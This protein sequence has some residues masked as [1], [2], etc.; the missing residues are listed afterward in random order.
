MLLFS[1]F[2]SS[3]ALHFAND[4]GIADNLLYLRPRRFKLDRF[5]VNTR[6][7]NLSFRNLMSLAVSQAA[8]WVAISH[9]EVLFQQVF[10]QTASEFLNEP[11]DK[12]LASFNK[13]NFRFNLKHVVLSVSH[14]CYDINNIEAYPTWT[15]TNHYWAN[16][17]QTHLIPTYILVSSSRQHRKLHISSLDEYG[18][19]YYKRFKQNFL[20]NTY[21]FVLILKRATVTTI[22]LGLFLCHDQFISNCCSD[23]SGWVMLKCQML[24]LFLHET[25]SP[26]LE[27]TE[28]DDCVMLV[29]IDTYLKLCTFTN[30]LLTISFFILIIIWP[31]FLNTTL[32]W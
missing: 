7:R 23:I 11:L 20:N 4:L 19:Y 1:K 10:K 15:H 3:S 6:K 24:P 26:M 17:K 14:K 12:V 27:I 25:V 9:S 13:L 32:L 2:S 18:I 21:K 30:L 22:K 5:P 8:H 28:M 29:F 16:K 31:N